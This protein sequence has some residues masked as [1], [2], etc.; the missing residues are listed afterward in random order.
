MG[1]VKCSKIR[2][3]AVGSG[4]FGRFPNCDKCRSEVAGDVIPCVAVDDVGMDVRATLGD[5]GLDSGPI[6]L[7]FGRPDPF[8]ASLLSSI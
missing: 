7:L 5:S 2:P 8:H 1:Q 6:I 4:I 3:H